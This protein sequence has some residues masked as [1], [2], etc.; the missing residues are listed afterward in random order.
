MIEGS[1]LWDAQAAGNFSRRSHVSIRRGCYEGLF[2]KSADEDVASARRARGRD[3]LPGGSNRG[4]GGG[5]RGR[6]G[7]CALGA[8]RDLSSDQ[9]IDD[10]LVVPCPILSAVS[11]IPAPDPLEYCGA[12]THVPSQK[13]AAGKSPKT[14]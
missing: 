2:H 5:P 1:A 3:C 12:F 4:A 8:E 9:R 14:E 6:A 11:C 7:R 13:T 10:C